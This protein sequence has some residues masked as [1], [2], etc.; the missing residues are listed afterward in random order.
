[1][2]LINRKEKTYTTTTVEEFGR[3]VKG[4]KDEAMAQLS[5]EQQKMMEQLWRS[6]K[7]GKAPKVAIKKLGSGGEIAGYPTSK[8]SGDRGWEKL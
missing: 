4:M 7:T 1:M 5:P 6:P 3:T 2:T 8:Y